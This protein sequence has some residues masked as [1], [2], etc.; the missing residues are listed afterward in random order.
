MGFNS[1]LKGLRDHT[2][3]H[4]P[5]WVLTLGVHIPSLMVLPLPEASCLNFVL[6]NTIT[7]NLQI[8]LYDFCELQFHLWKEE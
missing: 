3:H 4:V 8:F 6:C 1:G 5:V 2:V 7:Y